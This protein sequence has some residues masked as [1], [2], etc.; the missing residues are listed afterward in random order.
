MG[1]AT[2]WQALRCITQQIVNPTQNLTRLPLS[3]QT[4]SPDP[5]E[6]TQPTPRP[7]PIPRPE[8]PLTGLQP[9]AS[10]ATG[11]ASAAPP[12]RSSAHPA[13]RSD[14]PAPMLSASCA[15][16]LAGSAR[17]RSGRWLRNQAGEEGRT[18]Y[19]R[20]TGG[21]GGGHTAPLL[22]G[23]SRAR[24]SPFRRSRPARHSRVCGAG[25]RRDPAPGPPPGAA[26]LPRSL[27]RVMLHAPASEPAR[28]RRRASSP[29]RQG[30]GQGHDR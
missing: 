12:S 23:S 24:H 26:R 20:R 9:H 7:A 21:S 10:T 28:A 27:A 30:S 2:S 15:P 6:F 13:H 4:A 5:L 22:H 16:R 17:S 14:P 11:P 29:G 1:S 3:P 18:Q 25:S 19:V 8:H